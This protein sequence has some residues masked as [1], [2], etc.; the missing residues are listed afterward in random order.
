MA[1]IKDLAAIKEKYQRVTPLRQEDYL[2]GVQ[3]PKRDWAQATKA[4]EN[5]YEAGVQAAITRN[6]FGKG[7]DKAGTSKWQEGAVSKGPQ[8]FAEGVAQGADRYAD[9]FAPYQQAISS[10]T[11]PAKFPKGDPRNIKRV[12]AVTEAL[13]K[14]K[15]A[16]G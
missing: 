7:V 10:L 12:S 8:R 6:A 3:N 2:N 13:R 14:K 5:T 11:L 9:G 4:A 1:A 15:L 16:I